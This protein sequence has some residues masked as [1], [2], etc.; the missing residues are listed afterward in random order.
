MGESRDFSTLDQIAIVLRYVDKKGDVIERFVEVQHVGDITS[1]KLKETIDSFFSF[2]KLSFSKLCGQSYDG[3]SNMNEEFSDLKT[4]ILSKQPCEFYVHC[5]T[6]NLEICLV[7]AAKKNAEI[8]IFFTYVISAINL[9]GALC[10]RRDALGEQL[11][12]ELKEAFG[13]DFLMERGMNQETSL[14]HTRV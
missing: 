13:N 7:V 3:T 12:K 8:A 10:H 1:S 14:K 11:H 5:F 6:Q 2:N 4:K 9:V